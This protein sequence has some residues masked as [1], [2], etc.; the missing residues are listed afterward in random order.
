[1]SNNKQYKVDSTNKDL[2]GAITAIHEQTKICMKAY[3]GDK[4]ILFEYWVILCLL[5]FKK[6][7]AHQNI[8]I[9]L[10]WAVSHAKK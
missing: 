9:S 7:E 6:I 10:F 4:T 1:M 3:F 2:L 8:I 5:I